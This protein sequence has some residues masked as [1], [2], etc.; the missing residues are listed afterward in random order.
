MMNGKILLNLVVTLMMR[1]Y[2]F[3]GLLA[4]GLTKVSKLNGGQPKLVIIIILV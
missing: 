3:F 1:L 2:Q 4:K